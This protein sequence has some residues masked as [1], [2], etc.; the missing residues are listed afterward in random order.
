MNVPRRILV[1]LV[2]L[3]GAVAAAPAP[4]HAAAVTPARSPETARP[5]RVAAT[6]MA[7]LGDSITRG[8]NACG[9]YVDCPSR[10]WS[11]GTSTRVDSHYLRLL[12]DDPSMVAY[13]DARSGA[14]IAD[15]PGQ[16]ELAVSQRAGYVTILMGANDA[17]TSSEAGMTSVA[18]FEASFRTAM[19]T[20]VTGL[21]EA[22]IFVASIPDVR[23]LWQVGK[24]SSAAR[25]A[26]AA[27]GICQS[28]LAR[29]RSTDQADVDRRE[30][31]RQ[32]VADFNA[33]LAGVCAEQITCRYDGGAVFGYPFEL[34][35]VSRWDYF[36]P[37]TSGQRLLA[38]VTYPAALGG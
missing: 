22:S 27:F 37:N 23:R 38:E 13:N 12:A 25:S 21:P 32:R 2:A 17:C 26:W 31:V 3:A 5:V 9:F 16:A 33:V 28:M 14:R 6:A 19:R 8:F 10:S 34:S 4:A 18:D 36:H 7:S 1:V 11:T 29:P 24:D 30:R 20:L 15:L 35:H